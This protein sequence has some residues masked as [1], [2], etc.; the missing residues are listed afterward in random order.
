MVV[1]E[2]APYRGCAVSEFTTSSGQQWEMLAAADRDRQPMTLLGT[3]G[4]TCMGADMLRARGYLREDDT[5]VVRTIGLRQWN[6]RQKYRSMFNAI[7]MHNAKRQGNRSFEDT[8]RT[9]RAPLF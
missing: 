1:V 7:D 4:T 6:I 5:Y 2:R 9:R 8:W 3:E